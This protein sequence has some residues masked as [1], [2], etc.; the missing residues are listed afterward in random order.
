MRGGAEKEEAIGPFEYKVYRRIT[1]L[2]IIPCYRGVANL[3]LVMIIMIIRST[4]S[5]SKDLPHINVHPTNKADFID[6]GNLISR[7]AHGL[8]T[9]GS[10]EAGKGHT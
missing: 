4:L 5:P 6:L 7:A 3:L 1:G 9:A 10:M 2:K 8:T